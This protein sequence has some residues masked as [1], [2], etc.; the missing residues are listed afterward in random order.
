MAGSSKP[1][2]SYAL[3]ADSH[4]ESDQ[5]KID[6]F[7]VF[8]GVGVWATPANRNCSLVVG[9]RDIPA[10]TF[11]ISIWL[12]SAGNKAEH[13]ATGQ[14]E[15]PESE[16]AKAIAIQ[17]PLQLSGVGKHEVGV[18]IGESVRGD[19]FWVPFRVKKRKWPE[20]PTGD[21]LREALD[22]PNVVSSAR[23]ILT[24]DE[25]G[26]EHVLQKN[27]DPEEPIEPP[28]KPFPEDGVLRCP[29]CGA[30]HHVKDIEGQVAAQLGESAQVGEE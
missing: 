8:T 7:G 4:S 1:T 20:P 22:D 18:T 5:G 11:E 21:A 19:V 27:L 16:H 30:E 6:V 15:S 25:C 23:A 29:E 17:I 13:V 14:A 12:R 24:C 2:V 3:L 9:L 28:A 26:T 10:G